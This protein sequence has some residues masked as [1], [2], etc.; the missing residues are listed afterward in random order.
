VAHGLPGLGGANKV[1]KAESAAI[2]KLS[3]GSIVIQTDPCFVYT[4]VLSAVC[5][6]VSVCPMM[7]C[8]SDNQS[9]KFCDVC[10]LLVQS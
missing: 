5:A 1:L 8:L 3:I 7:L 6:V 4:Y 10:G 9:G 2:N